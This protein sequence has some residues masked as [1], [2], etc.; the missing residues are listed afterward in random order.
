MYILNC[1][2][3]LMK[4]QIPVNDDTWFKICAFKAYLCCGVWKDTGQVG[5]ANNAFKICKFTDICF[6]VCAITL[7]TSVS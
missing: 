7:K 1:D 5:C 4:E 2:V 3:C 6:P